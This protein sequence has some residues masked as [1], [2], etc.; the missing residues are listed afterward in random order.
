MT[1][2]LP[3]QLFYGGDY[4]P[5]QWSKDVWL[6][7]MRLMRAAG[8]NL[9]TLGVF[10]W[11]NIETSDGVYEFGWLD[12]IINLLHENGIGVDLATA[13][14][15]PPAWLTVAHPEVLPVNYH[16]TRLSH[17]GRQGYCISSPI[18]KAKSGQLARKLAARYSSH[19]AIKMWHVNNEYGC[20]NPICYCDVSALAWRVWLQKKYKNLDELNLAWGT[21]FWSQR[22]HRWEEILPPRETP[23][24]T[25]PNPSMVLDYRRFSNDEIL[26]LYRN[27]R[28]EIRAL[29]S[30]HPITTNFMSM[31]HTSVLDY[32]QWAPEVDFVATDHYLIAEDERNFIDLAFQADLTRGFAGGKPWLLMEHSTSAVNWQDRNIPKAQGEMVANS[33]SHV[34]R[35]S[36]GA[37]FFQW[38]QSISGSEKFHSAMVPHTGE[39]SRVWKSVQELGAK[40][41]EL[42]VLA[43]TETEVAE[44]AMIFDYQSWWALSQRNL[45]STSIDY[46]E[47][48]H[49]WYRALWDLGVRVDFVAPGSSAQE[50]A[51]YKMVLAPMVY[52]LGSNAEQ[53]LIDYSQNG[54]HLVASYFTGISDEVDG[55]KLGGYGGRLVRECL[56]VFVDEFAPVRVGEAVRLSNGMAAA[57]WSQF[58]NVT[59]ANLIAS[60]VGGVADGSAAIAQSHRGTYVGT[61]LD[62]DSNRTLFRSIVSKLGILIRGGG[63]V[64]V[65]RRGP[66]EITIDHK[67]NAVSWSKND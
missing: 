18:Y 49:D 27:E 16:G 23:I 67:A 53:A 5:E 30:E 62:D 36:N 24:G 44:V 33:L 38:R 29:D 14:A 31:K 32:W 10:S 64:E 55:V 51:K 50:L 58:A 20:H 26:D 15:S 41:G 61:R 42:A 60:F 63:G 3:S 12:E 48:A 19:P 66:L 1:L 22:Y 8:V 4:N 11:A 59:S 57:E 56:G 2:A 43:G 34:A 45:P 40:L 9:V 46:P 13:T 54:G 25:Y 6:E 35:G 65:I 39:Q 47:L 52:L 28:D 37:M 21:N 17:G 7:D